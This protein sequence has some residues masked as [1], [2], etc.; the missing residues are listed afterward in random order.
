MFKQH[1]HAIQALYRLLALHPPLARYAFFS[2]FWLFRDP[3]HSCITKYFLL[4]FYPR[5]AS[6][7][8]YL[9]CKRQKK[10]WDWEH[11]TSRGYTSLHS[12]CV[13][14][15]AK[16]HK[17]HFS[18]EGTPKTSLAPTLFDYSNWPGTFNQIHMALLFWKQE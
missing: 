5:C 9:H 17:K 2:F 11:A 10:G 14:T 1:V 12:E 3:V 6:C 16:T 13:V 15:R 18:N 4:P 8:K 7:Q